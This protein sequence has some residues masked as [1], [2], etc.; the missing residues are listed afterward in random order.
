MNASEETIFNVALD[1]HDSQERSAYLR[2][3]C[4]GDTTLR[5][6]IEQ[7]VSAYSEGAFLET[8]AAGLTATLHEEFVEPLG[9][10]IGP[11]KLLEQIGEGGMGLVYM[12][13]QQRPVRRLVALKLIKPGMDSKQVIARFEAEKQALA[14]MDHQNIAKVLDAGT[15]NTG[16][17]Y[18]AMELVRGIPINVFCDEARLTARERLELMVQVCQAVQHAHQKGII[19]RDLKPSNV[20]VTMND[21]MPLP[22]VID[23]GIAKALG[24]SLTDHTLHTGFAQLVGTPLYM[25]PEQAS[26]NHLGVDTRSDV[27]S[28]GV[29]LYELLTGT[30]PFDKETLTKAGLDEMRRMIREDEPPRPSDRVSTLDAQALSTVSKGR[31]TDPRRISIILRGELDWIVMKALEKDRSRR[32]ESPSALAADIQ[33]YLNGDFVQACPPSA[34]YRFR[35]LARRHKAAISTIGLVAVSLF[36]GIMVSSWHAIRASHAE[37]RAKANAASAFQEKL[38]SRDEERK[39]RYAEQKA[40]SAAAA[41][42]KAKQAEAAQR[43]R[44][45]ANER[46]AMNAAQQAKESEAAAKKAEADAKQAADQAKAALDFIKNRILAAARVQ[47]QWDGLGKDVMLREAIDAAEPYIAK[48]FKDQPV[49]EAEI[50]LTLGLT[51]MSLGEHEL[52]A[53]QFRRAVEIKTSQLTADDPS[54]LYAKFWLASAYH[55]AGKLEEALSLHKQVR[56]GRLAKLGP[57]HSSILDSNDGL[58][59]VYLALGK[60]EQALPLCEETLKKTRA[61]YGPDHPYTLGSMAELALAYTKA[62]RIDECVGLSEETLRLRKAKIGLEHP[63]TMASMSNLALAYMAAAKFE[64]ALPLY[65][66]TFGL[67]R[68][69]LGPDHPSTLATM[70]LIVDCYLKSGMFEQAVSAGE[71]SLR[72]KK[73][74]LGLD[75]PSTLIS[76]NNLALVYCEAGKLPQAILLLEETLR[77]SEGKLGPEHPETLNTMMN[78]AAIYTGAQKLDQALPLAEK[79]LKL[80]RSNLGPGHPKTLYGMQTLGD[81]NLK[82][83][84]YATAAELSR[85]RLA[86]CQERFGL[87]NRI[88][89]SSM[90]NL[91]VCLLYQQNYV[92]AESLLRECSTVSEKLWPNDWHTFY[93]KSLL[94]SALAG[95]AVSFKA[96]DHAAAAQKFAEAEPLLSAG[97]EGMKI[98]EK[99]LGRAGRIS[100]NAALMRLIQLYSEWDKPAEAARWKKELDAMAAEAPK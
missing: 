6:R 54:T 74:K 69:K 41:E 3:A 37:A 53:R 2:Q 48:D 20:L 34:A 92:E 59:K 60:L 22:K 75:H 61:A 43:K 65:E 72:L 68:A 81:V 10:L 84:N 31:N 51:Y 16:R 56:E 12:A 15:T 30:T 44:A 83:K 50:R 62:G 96:T 57:N 27:Y 52:A 24:P 42:S 55:R 8:P 73:A 89:M 71:E 19:H 80:L 93:K 17:P 26:L 98:R 100:T 76:M 36:I 66:E 11:F 63:E 97:Y 23:F 4:G 5:N 18:F 49:M 13:E 38:V 45:E 32:Y 33:R 87:E 40:L 85:E 86:V 39:A 91:G 28:L 7:L 78:L 79:A 64:L 70:G 88:T 9:T 95:L 35:K 29:L 14:M 25:S 1:K 58:A 94:G 99:S 21:A 46:Q 47:G 82:A 67:Q 90:A 77:L